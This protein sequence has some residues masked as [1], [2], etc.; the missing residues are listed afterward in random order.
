MSNKFHNVHPARAF[1]SAS[2]AAVAV[3]AAA[4]PEPEKKLV[5]DGV[6]EQEKEP[7]MD[8]AEQYQMADV[9]LKTAAAV[10]EWAE[11]SKDDLDEGE[12]L[13]NRLF[14]LLLGVADADA[15]GEIGDDEADAM[16][17]AQE[18][19]YDYLIGK[20][21]SESDVDALLNEFDDEV[22]DR[23]Q[24]LLADRLPSGEDESNADIESFAFG[25]GSDASV[26]DGVS[27]LDAVYK[28]R[29]AF[30][31]GKKTL[32]KKRVAGTVRLSAKQKM[33]VRKMLRKSQSAAAMMRRAKSVRARRLAGK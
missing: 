30:R 15:N 5:L 17:M 7:V 2:K 1:L 16:M 22:A 11:T 31:N 19:A 21:V 8:A 27:A 23:V 13:G 18:A 26:M 33:A 3:A 29:I 28:K 6:D 12:G 24:E 4:T 9:A 25:D 20:G 32:I 14:A 10:Q